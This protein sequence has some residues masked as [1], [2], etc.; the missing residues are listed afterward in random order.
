MV[1]GRS[2][3]MFISRRLQYSSTAITAIVGL[4]PAWVISGRFTA[5]ISAPGCVHVPEDQRLGLEIEFV[6]LGF[7]LHRIAYRLFELL[8]ITRPCAHHMTEV[9]GMFLA[10]TEQQAPF[11]GKAHA[12]AV[13]AEIVAVRGDESNPGIGVREF[14]IPGW[15]PGRFRRGD[16]GKYLFQIVADPVA[17]VI[18]LCA[19][20]VVIEPE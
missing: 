6:T 11:A 14:E 19:V 5:L 18:D 13:I 8:Q 4:R 16:Q 2:S 10:Q 9:H 15:T 1:R 20:M 7:D 17:G 12:I 3:A